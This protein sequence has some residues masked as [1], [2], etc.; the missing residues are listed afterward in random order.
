MQKWESR[1]KHIRPPLLHPASHFQVVDVNDCSVRL[2]RS[3]WVDSSG[4]ERENIICQDFVTRKWVEL[5]IFQHSSSRTRGR[6]SGSN[7]K[8]CM[9]KHCLV[10]DASNWREEQLASCWGPLKTK[11]KISIDVNNVKTAAREI[12]HWQRWV[13]VMFLCCHCCLSRNNNYMRLV[14]LALPK[15]FTSVAIII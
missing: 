1:C 3:L 7:L 2:I 4:E 14:L 11:N 13:W 12:Q 9:F 8:P 5:F 6:T 15:D 10:L